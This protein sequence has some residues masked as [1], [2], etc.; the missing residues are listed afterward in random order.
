MCLLKVVD[1]FGFLGKIKGLRVWGSV[2]KEGHV[3]DILVTKYIKKE[4]LMVEQ[5]NH[6]SMETRGPA[7][8]REEYYRWSKVHS[9]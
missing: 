3:E 9:S 7:G 6:C 2:F 5:R 4:N 8:S 1:A